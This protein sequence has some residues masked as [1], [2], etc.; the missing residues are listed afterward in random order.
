MQKEREGNLIREK[1]Q[2]QMK[3]VMDVARSIKFMTYRK[4]ITNLQKSFFINNYLKYKGVALGGVA[5]WLSAGL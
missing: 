5:Q 2:S 1:Q 3:A 4:Q